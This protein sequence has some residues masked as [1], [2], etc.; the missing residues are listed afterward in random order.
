[1][2]NRVVIALFLKVFILCE[3]R[4][5]ILIGKVA[6]FLPKVEIFG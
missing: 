3:F 1:M 2:R 5:Y 4:N 6:T